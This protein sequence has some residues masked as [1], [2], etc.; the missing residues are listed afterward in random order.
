M[1][2]VTHCRSCGKEIIWLRGASTGRPAPIEAAPDPDG[3]LHVDLDKGTYHL[4]NVGCP[5]EAPRYLNHF[6]RCPAR[7]WKRKQPQAVRRS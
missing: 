3:N 2:E 1:A 4:V 6:A 5:Q 7:D